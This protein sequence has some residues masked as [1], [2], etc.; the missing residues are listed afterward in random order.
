NALTQ[1]AIQSSPFRTGVG[2]L[3]GGPI[4][5]RL[6]PLLVLAGIRLGISIAVVQLLAA[7]VIAAQVSDDAIDPGIKRALEAESSDIAVGAQKGFL[8]NI[9]G[10]FGRVGQVGG[11]P[12]DGAIVVAD[13]FF[14]GGSIALLSTS[15]QHGV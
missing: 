14:E 5:N 9:L 7:Q 1:F 15:H 10:I 4:Q 13:Q 6:L 3:V 12:Q 11:Q 2:P 8:I